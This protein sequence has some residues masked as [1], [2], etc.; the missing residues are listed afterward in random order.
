MKFTRTSRIRGDECAS[1]AV[2]EY[3]AK[4]VREFVNEVLQNTKEWGYIKV[5]VEGISWL[6]YPEC[7]YRYGNFLSTLPAEYLDKEITKVDGDGGWSRMDY[8]V[9]VKD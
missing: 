5:V 2:T 1:Y 6:E 8:Y 9:S 4:T 7:E 3:K